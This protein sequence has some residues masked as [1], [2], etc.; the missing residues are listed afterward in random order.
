[1][2]GGVGESFSGSIDRDAIR[3]VVEQNLKTIK[4]CY[5]RELNRNPDLAGKVLLE[6]DIAEQGRVVGTR[7]NQGAPGF[8]RV[9]ECVLDRLK[10]WRFPE[11]PSN[12][13]VTVVYPFVF[14]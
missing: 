3:R 6:W 5:E 9:S 4:A 1:M 12:Q 11:P 2:P 14:E 13:S 7:V 10:T 8:E